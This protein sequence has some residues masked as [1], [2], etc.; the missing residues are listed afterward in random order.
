MATTTR[1]YTPDRVMSNAVQTFYLTF[2]FGARRE[3]GVDLLHM[4]SR[5]IE[6]K[7]RSRARAREIAEAK[8]GHEGWQ[9][10][11]EDGFPETRRRFYPDGC[12][13]IIPDL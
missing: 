13:L 5:W 7:T 2:P 10:N 1:Y 4:G 8:F 12:C 3:I 9:L 11:G 6:I